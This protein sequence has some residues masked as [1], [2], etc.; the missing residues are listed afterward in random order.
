MNKQPD[1]RTRTRGDIMDAF[2]IL[3]RQNPI[4][5]ITVSQVIETAGYNRSTFYRYFDSVYD[6]LDAIEN[7]IFD[8]WETY[9]TVILGNL[10]D[11]TAIIEQFY[12]DNDRYLSTLLNSL[13]SPLYVDKFKQRLQSSLESL[14][15][16]D[17]S[18]PEKRFILEFY[19]AG[20]FS[21][22]TTWYKSGKL[23]SSEQLA[24]MIRKT[25]SEK[26]FQI[27]GDMQ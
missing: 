8:Q 3:Y 21:T 26:V 10:S 12:Q 22:I 23:I 14:F 16:V 6:I 27:L 11:F 1:R 4:D 13:N 9:Q 24:E 5:K 7:E 17:D 19:I 20:A 15:Q 18:E 2:C 25:Y